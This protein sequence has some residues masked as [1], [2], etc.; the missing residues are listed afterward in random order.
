M[1]LKY[2]DLFGL[3]LA[4]FFTRLI[5]LKI[6]P[7]FTDEAIYTY[8]AQIALHDPV[9]RFVSLE[10]GKQPLFVW[11]GAVFQKFISDPLIA[12]RLV[13]V[14]AGFGSLIA[15]YLLTKT[16]FDKKI[17]I[18][19]V[20]FYIILPFTLLYDRMALF[21][22]LLTMFGVFSAYLAVKIAKSPKLSVGALNGLVIGLGLITKSSANF[23]IYLLPFSYIFLN[24][25]KLFDKKL[26]KWLAVST[27][28]AIIAQIV[29]NMLRLSPLFY[30]IDRK[31]YEFIRSFGEILKNPLIQIPSNPKTIA[32]WFIE[33]NG[34]PFI[35]LVIITSLYTIYKRKVEALILISYVSLPFLAE[36]IFNKVLYPRF[37]LFFFPYII[38]IAAFGLDAFRK[39]HALLFIPVI[40]ITLTVPVFSSFKLLTNPSHSLIAQADKEQYL[41][42]WPAGYG[43]SEVVTFLK[44]ESQNHPVIVGTEGTFGLLPFALQIYFY[45]NKNVQISGYWP[46]KDIP[47]QI[48]ESAKHNKTYFIFNENQK[49]SDTTINPHLKLIAKYQKGT[50]N[51]YMR[52][53]EIVE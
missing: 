27:L 6:V 52:F 50:G 46:V 19:A 25:A 9:N 36:S 42:S 49:I 38:I 30:M 13:S 35:A 5:N 3:S 7:I 24:F 22:S 11:L 33:Y 10:D 51:S 15:I 40:I 32:T 12:M 18:L 14:F 45:S 8:W 31:N 28:T 37:S 43:V 4:F 34:W 26:V 29:Y 44:A 17:A 39:K 20:I 23:F 47:Q 53:F 48:L 21:D 16:L 2:L 1:K 41:N